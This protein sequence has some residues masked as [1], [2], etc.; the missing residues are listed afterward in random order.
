MS[1]KHRKK[2]FNPNTKHQP[3]NG[4]CLGEH[5]TDRNSPPSERDGLMAMATIA[6]LVSGT[7]R[8]SNFVNL[9]Q[10][11]TKRNM[12]MQ[13]IQKELNQLENGNKRD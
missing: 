7:S 4:Y 1:K 6:S 5:C 2:T 12:E 11:D 3:I 10:A 13:Q 9:L 8:L